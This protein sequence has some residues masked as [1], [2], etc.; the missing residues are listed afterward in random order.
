MKASFALAIMLTGCL[1]ER[2]VDKRLARLQMGLNTRR[3]AVPTPTEPVRGALARTTSPVEPD[4]ATEVMSG[5]TGAMQFT[6]RQT[7]NIYAGGEIEAGPM[8]REGSYFG[9]AYGVLGA[10]ARSL[11]GSISVELIAG[12]QW[13]RY[14]FDSGDVPVN[15]LEPRARGQLAVSEQVSLGGV[16]GG[17]LLGEGGWMAGIYVGVYSEPVAH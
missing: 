4:P 10:E 6:M 16:I 3:V 17:G 13:L 1:W 14:N 2:N 8:Q 15:V 12:R 11:R 9:A 7:R 5:V